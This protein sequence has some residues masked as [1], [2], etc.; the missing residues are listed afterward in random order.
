MQQLRSHI[1]N[2]PY[3]NQHIMEFTEYME[4]TVQVIQQY[5]DGILLKQN[6][7]IETLIHRVEKLEQNANIKRNP[8]E[9]DIVATKESLE[10]LKRTIMGIFR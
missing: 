4:E 3:H 6:E 7:I 10:K 2:N 9:V 8:F 1:P 5:Y